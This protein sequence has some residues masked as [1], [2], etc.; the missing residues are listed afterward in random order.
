M[1]GAL[2]DRAEVIPILGQLHEAA[3]GRHALKMPDLAAGL[4]ESG[5]DLAG[6]LL[7]VRVVAG[8]AQHGGCHVHA[9]QR[10]GDDVE[11]LAGLQRHVHADGRRQLARPHARGEDDRLGL[12]VTPIGLHTA[13]PTA[14]GL[15]PRDGHALVD[16]CTAVAR[17]LRQRHGH[18]HRRELAVALHQQ[19]A[20]QIVGM[21]ERPAL[22]QLVEVQN[23]GLDAHHR[24]HRRAAEH[25]L[26][27]L[28]VV[29]HGDRALC[30][31]TRR[32][33]GLLLQL[34]EQASGVGGELREAE[35]GAELRDESCGVPGGAAGEGSLLEDHH[36]ADAAPRQVVGGAATD[37]AAADDDHLRPVGKAS[38]DTH[39]ATF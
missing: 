3:A 27:A 37:H 36:V 38:A 32:L 9:L 4:E 34:L 26:P 22:L 17:P 8:I 33:A 15:Q 28:R 20:H 25:L 13:D 11:V 19:G 30:A 6:L 2:E 23:A 31:E 39:E 24:P 7:E 35:C 16:G 21:Y 12:D 18:V 14:A 1:D 29:G 10:L 5:H